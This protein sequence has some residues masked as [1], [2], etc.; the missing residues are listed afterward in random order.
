MTFSSVGGLSL[1]EGHLDLSFRDQGSWMKME[2]AGH[3]IATPQMMF[4]GDPEAGPLLS[5]NAVGGGEE[6]VKTFTHFHGSDQFRIILRG[7]EQS[8]NR[9]TFGPGQFAFQEAGMPYKEGVGGRDEVW[10]LVIV[11]D[12]RGAAAT[13]PLGDNGT[14]KSVP[15]NMTPEEQLAA[16]E[17]YAMFNE[18]AKRNPGGPKGI[19][20]VATTLGTRRGGM[21]KASFADRDGWLRFAPGIEAAAGCWGDRT[22][23]PAQVMLT[24]EPGRVA[25]PRLTAATEMITVVV[26]GSCEIGASSYACGDMRIQA[27]GSP[28]DAVVAGPNGVELVFIVA[29]RSCLAALETADE[30]GAGWKRALTDILG[31]LESVLAAA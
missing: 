21:V 18:M 23:G 27:A 24:V 16:S 22:S 4:V 15:E 20:S 1:D 19:P 10:A 29:D 6:G 2:H 5:V 14:Y 9:A 31:G 7:V 12:R 25:V 3:A 30:A 17:G 26:D 8:V 11:G 13:M 28:Q